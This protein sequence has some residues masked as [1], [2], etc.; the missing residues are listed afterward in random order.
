MV[1]VAAGL[2]VTLV[3]ASAVAPSKGVTEYDVIVL[4]P[5]AGA[6]QETVADPFPG[7]TVTTVGAAGVVAGVTDGEAAEGRL[8]PTAFD[9]VTVNVY[10]VPL[11]NPLMLAVVPV[12][13]TCVWAVVPTYGVTR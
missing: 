2:P 11:V 5:F 4:P 9:A 12:A 3:A 7:V 13:V 1:D 6:V 10:P 8:D